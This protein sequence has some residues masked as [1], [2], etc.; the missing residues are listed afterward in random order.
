M[1]SQLARTIQ[2]SILILFCYGL[3]TR[4]LDKNKQ[5]QQQKLYPAPYHALFLR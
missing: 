1:I 5:D 2:V 4:S 3:W